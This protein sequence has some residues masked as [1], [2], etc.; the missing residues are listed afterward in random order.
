MRWWIFNKKTDIRCFFI[1]IENLWTWRKVIWHDRH[2]DYGFLLAVMEFKFKLMSEHFY[3]HGVCTDKNDV[4]RELLKCS[5]LAKRV[6]EEN[7]D[8]SL[9]RQEELLQ[10]D[11]EL[12]LKTMKKKM[13]TWWD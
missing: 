13:R 3:N 1:G 7:Y 6:R 11:F 5:L 9:D 12:L 10:Q 4:G 2:W 8:G